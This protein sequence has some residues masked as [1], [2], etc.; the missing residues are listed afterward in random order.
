MRPPAGMRPLGRG[1]RPDGKPAD[2]DG[3]NPCCPI[4]GTPIPL[5]QGMLRDDDA[6]LHIE[7]FDGV[8]RWVPSTGK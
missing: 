6:R 5:G 3:A 1:P 7:C 8:T 4:C 2:G